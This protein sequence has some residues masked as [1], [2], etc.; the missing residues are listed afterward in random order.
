MV[1]H[2]HCPGEDDQDLD[3]WAATLGARRTKVQIPV[4]KRPKQQQQQQVGSVQRGG[5]H[6][7][8]QDQA[9]SARTSMCH[10]DAKY[11]EE[12]CLL[13]EN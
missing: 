3:L 7:R 2:H 6:R 8:V 1:V 10:Y 13:L 9:A 11:G 12:G 5:P 4:S